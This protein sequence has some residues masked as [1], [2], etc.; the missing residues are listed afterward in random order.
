MK[1]VYDIRQLLKKY[2]T[3]IY[4]GDRIGDLDLMEMEINELY[5]MKFIAIWDYQMAKLILKSEK[6][7]L[8]T[9]KG[10]NNS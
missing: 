6:N 9:G 3:F 1:S 8:S 5:E 7:R 4:T 10:E 2:G